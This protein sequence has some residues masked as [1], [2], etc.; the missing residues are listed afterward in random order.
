MTLRLEEV[1][2]LILH[3]DMAF[4]LRKCPSVCVF[5][6]ICDVWAEASE[7]TS[8]GAEDLQSQWLFSA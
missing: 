3:D 4:V 1:F 8:K 7:V 2:C 5:R 6:H